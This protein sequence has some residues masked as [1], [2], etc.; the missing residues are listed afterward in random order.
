MLVFE[1]VHTKWAQNSHTRKKKTSYAAYRHR[2]EHIVL[3]LA[4]FRSAAYIESSL[5]RKPLPLKA[6]R[7]PG[8]KSSKVHVLHSQ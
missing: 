1:C 6:G 8:T 3:A 5:V 7:G 2:V 4:C